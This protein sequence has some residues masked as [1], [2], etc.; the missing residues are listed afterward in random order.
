M[1][2]RMVLQRANLVRLLQFRIS[3]GWG[4]LV[5]VSICLAD[6]K[7]S[8][9]VTYAKNIVVFRFLGHCDGGARSVRFCN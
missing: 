3:R 1:H 6:N 2:T 5:Q 7:R 4:D 9:E 8:S